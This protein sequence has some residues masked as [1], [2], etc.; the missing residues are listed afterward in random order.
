M[1]LLIRKIDSFTLHSDRIRCALIDRSTLECRRFHRSR[2]SIVRAD[3]AGKIYQQRGERGISK[4]RSTSQIP[5]KEA[6][7]VKT[8]PPSDLPSG[9][10]T[11]V[12]E[13]HKGHPDHPR[14]TDYLAKCRWNASCRRAAAATTITRVREAPRSMNFCRATSWLT[15]TD[16]AA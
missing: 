10:R 4:K 14:A 3:I 8:Q 15:M 6:I 12:V 1:I 11:S 16:H 9:A 2:E 5:S 13:K 7:S